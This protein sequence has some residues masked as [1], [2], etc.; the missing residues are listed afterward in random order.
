MANFILR[1]GYV[2]RMLTAYKVPILELVLQSTF[3]TANECL[4]L[5][6]NARAS[7]LQ[8]LDLSCNPI[9]VLGLLH[10]TNPRTSELLSLKSLI[11]VDCDI[12]Q[13]QTYMVS[14]DRLENGRCPFHLRRLN[15]SHNKLSLFLNYVTELD[16]INSDLE[17]L[18]LVQ[19]EINDE[20]IL[21]MIQADKLVKLE[22]LDL[23]GNHLEKSY[24]VLAKYLREQCD[25]MMNLY[26]RD[27]VGLKHTLNNF[28]I[29]KPKKNSGLPLLRRLDLTRSL[30]GDP[31]AIQ[32]C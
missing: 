16:L 2:D 15:L 22:H 32:L 17:T 23:S 20:Q 24:T 11:L 1:I 4:V 9:S 6:A 29:A 31:Q 7:Q 25:H 12:D 26:L 13:S 28:Q 10:L 19:C 3:I 27:N 14:N 5:A 30:R 18:E 8:T 21:A